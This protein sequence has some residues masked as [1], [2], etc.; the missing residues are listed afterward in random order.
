VAELA[1]LLQIEAAWLL[2]DLLL[3]FYFSLQ[4]HLGAVVKCLGVQLHPF[5]FIIS[6]Q[7]SWL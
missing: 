1:I 3:I 4:L 5:L 7:V 6:A 2:V